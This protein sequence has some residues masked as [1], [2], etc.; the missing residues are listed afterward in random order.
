MLLSGCLERRTFWSHALN[1]AF[2]GYNRIEGF[3]PSSGLFTFPVVNVTGLRVNS[4]D[5]FALGEVG[6]AIECSSCGHNDF[7]GCCRVDAEGPGDF[8]DRGSFLQKP[9]SELELID[10]S[11][12]A[13]FRARAKDHPDDSLLHYLLAEQLAQAPSDA[14]THL[15]RDAVSAAE[16]ATTLEPS[17]QPAHDLLASLYLRAKQP[18]L[19]IKE[20]EL[21]LTLNQMMKPPC[22]KS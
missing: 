7:V 11:L 20:A 18:E 3:S 16:R 19:A 15:L 6:S 4:G 9:S 2:V 1:E 8:S 14:E 13:F 10:A 12:L 21:A 17:Y 5:G 22:I